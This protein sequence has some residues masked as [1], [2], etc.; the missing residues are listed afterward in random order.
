MLPSNFS[1]I[2]AFFPRLTSFI[3]AP[4]SEVLPS[5][6]HALH[7]SGE[8]GLFIG[9]NFLFGSSGESET[10]YNAPLARHKTFEILSFECWSLEHP[11]IC[12]STL[13]PS[14]SSALTHSSSTSFSLSPPIARHGNSRSLGSDQEIF[15]LV[16]PHKSVY[17]I[18]ESDSGGRE[19]YQHGKEC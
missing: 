8:F 1:E 2:L 14:S 9:D 11:M 15:S 5:L 16:S 12:P 10:F 18:F 6:S 17:E 3:I 19:R 13:H 4:D 7:P